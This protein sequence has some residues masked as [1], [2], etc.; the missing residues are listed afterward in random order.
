[1]YIFMLSQLLME[2]IYSVFKNRLN[3]YFIIKEYMNQIFSI[4]V[5]IKIVNVKKTKKSIISTKLIKKDIICE[6]LF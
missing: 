3:V 6:I 4:F 2:Q 5:L 1:M